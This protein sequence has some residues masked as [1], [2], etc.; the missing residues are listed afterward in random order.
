MI[1]NKRGAEEILTVWN[2]IIWTMIAI[3]IV[4]GTLVFYSAEINVK[5]YE[6]EI[7]GE[8]IIRCLITNNDNGLPIIKP[9]VLNE[10]YDIIE[11]CNLERKIIVG[12]GNYVIAMNITE[13]GTKEEIKRIIV[14][15]EVY[16]EVTC[17]LNKEG[18]SKD[19]PRCADRS[20]NLYP[21]N[22]PKQILR[23]TTGSN[24]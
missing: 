8:K 9:E 11:A 17:N 21:E 13:E 10:E 4:T 20:I 15:N 22:K 7:L 14:G 2:V 3:T 6:S 18:E 19:K 5:M 16:Y 12:V 23:I 24:Q 1:K